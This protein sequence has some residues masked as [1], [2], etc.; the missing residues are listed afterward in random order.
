MGGRST[1]AEYFREH[2]EFLRAVASHLR[3]DDS[4]TKLLNL[5]CHFEERAKA[6]EEEI[7]SSVTKENCKSKKEALPRGRSRTRGGVTA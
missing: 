7:R 1:K 3:R 2:A 5:A 4:R 6:A